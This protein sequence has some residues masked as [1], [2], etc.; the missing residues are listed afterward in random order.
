MNNDWAVSIDLTDPYLHADTSL[1]QKVSLIR[2]RRSDIP[3]HSL[4]LRNVSKSVNFYQIDGSY[5]IAPASTCHFRFSVPRL[6]AD[7][8]SDS[9]SAMRSDKIFPSS[10]SESRIYSKPK[11]V[12]INT[13]SEFHVHR[14]GISDTAEFSQGT[15]GT[16]RDPNI[17]YQI[18]SL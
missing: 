5:S 14:H 4:T 17:D 13:C 1:I 9:Q 8:K 11:K 15:S 16:S 2:L 18:C 3:V 7:K 12:G 10:S 6:L